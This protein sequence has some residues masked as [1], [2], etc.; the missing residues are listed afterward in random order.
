MGQALFIRQT[1]I[2]SVYEEDEPAAAAGVSPFTLSFTHSSEE[3]P[4]S[5]PP[6]PAATSL[7]HTL[8][9]MKLNKMIS[10]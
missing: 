4:D 3:L 5:T 9:T 8:D 7:H 2:H 10:E 6:P 1:F